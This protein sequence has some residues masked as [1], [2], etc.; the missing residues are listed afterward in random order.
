MKLYTQIMAGLQKDRFQKVNK[1]L[2]MAAALEFAQPQ[3]EFDTS[4]EI[5]AQKRF[6]HYEKAHRKG[7]LDPAFTFFSTWEYR[8]AINSDASNEYVIIA[9]IFFF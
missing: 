2:A 5:D 8:M 1:K 3:T 6:S 9:A 4:V 7:E